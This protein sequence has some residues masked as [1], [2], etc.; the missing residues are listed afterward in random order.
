MGGV[1]TAAREQLM[2]I[3]ELGDELSSLRMCEA[4]TLQSMRRSLVRHGQLT[5]VIAYR[6]ESTPGVQI[7]DG[8]KRLRGAQ[9]LEWA[10][11][12]VSV[13]A[14]T[15]DVEAKVRIAEL[16]DGRG[17]TEIEEAWL[18]Y[19]LCREHGLAQGAVAQQ[20]GRHKSW[21]CRRLMLVE[22]LDAA[23]QA[24]VRLGLL[25]ARAAVAL[26]QLPR[27]NQPAVAEIVVRRGLTVRQTEQLVAELL[28]A[29]DPDERARIVAA[30]NDGSRV[31]AD[32]GPQR[33]R[34][35]TEA[36][37]MLAD[38]AALCRISARLQAR[39]LGTPLLALGERPEELVRRALDSLEPVLEALAYTIG[40]ASSSGAAHGVQT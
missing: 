24:D 32:R 19:S 29:S 33:R 7:I 2:P 22:A 13:V 38:I 34:A 11:L 1:P 31:P 12:R 37:W 30:Y 35:R 14:V 40:H 25:V 5:A 26:A 36:E 28:A 27:G 9:A 23:V 16:H 10:E 17:L 4:P 20:L 15:S 3:A 39:L 8:F 21:V 18:V 6:G